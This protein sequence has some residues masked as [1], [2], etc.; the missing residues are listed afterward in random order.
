MYHVSSPKNRTFLL[1]LYHLMGVMADEDVME[2]KPF[3]HK[4]RDRMNM[5]TLC[6]DSIPTTIDLQRVSQEGCYCSET[7]RSK[8][9]RPPVVSGNIKIE[10]T[11][12]H[13]LQI[14][15]EL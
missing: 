13:F 12:H 14:H 3:A 1:R 8:M 15:F 4:S 9:L 11:P 7:L 10:F 2:C 5:N 6:A